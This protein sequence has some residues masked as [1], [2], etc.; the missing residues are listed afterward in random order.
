MRFSDD[1]TKKFN[2][3]PT[4]DLEAIFHQNKQDES[5]LRALSEVLSRRRKSKA[6]KRLRSDVNRQLSRFFNP[7]GKERTQRVS[8]NVGCAGYTE[9]GRKCKN[10]AMYFENDVGWC[11][12]HLPEQSAKPSR[13]HR[14]SGSRMTQTNNSHEAQSE[15]PSIPITIDPNV[16]IKA[17]DPKAITSVP[18][19]AALRKNLLESLNRGS[20]IN[21]RH[22]DRSR[23]HIRI[24]N[25]DFDNAFRVLAG[26]LSGSS[27]FAPLSEPPDEPSDERSE[28]FMLAYLA[29]RRDSQKIDHLESTLDPDDEKDQR[30]LAQAERKIK[31][32]VRISLG[33]GQRLQ[34]GVQTAAQIARS[35]KINPNHSLASETL[36]EPSGRITLQTLQYPREMSAKLNAIRTGA[37]RAM[38][39]SGS[40]ALHA[41]FGF[42]EWKPAGGR[43]RSIMSP[44]LLAPLEFSR[45]D[46][47]SRRQYVVY[48][49]GDDTTMNPALQVQLD[50]E[51]IM[52]PEWDGEE[53]PSHYLK[54][55]ESKISSKSGWKVHSFLTIGL[56]ESAVINV[57]QDLDP[58][59]WPEGTDPSLHNV[60]ADLMAGSGERSGDLV[61]EY[62]IDKPDIAN[63]L[64]EPVL[65]ADS[66]QLSAMIDVLDGKNLAIQG[67][68]GTGKSQTITNTIAAAMLRGK[69]VL[70]VAEKMAALD[71]VK[72]RLD[73][74]GLGDFVLELHSTK[75]SRASVYKSFAPRME[76]ARRLSKPFA[77]ERR[78]RELRSVK[79]TLNEYVDL[80]NKPLE[81]VGST[82]H[83]AMWRVMSLEKETFPDPLKAVEIKNASNIDQVEL[84][85]TRDALRAYQELHA[86]VSED[87]GSIELH[88]WNF[89]SKELTPIDQEFVRQQ[90]SEQLEAI[91]Q[92]KRELENLVWIGFSRDSSSTVSALK[93]ALADVF[94]LPNQL[95]ENVSDKL[96]KAIG[97]RIQRKSLADYCEAI[98][99]KNALSSDIGEF[100]TPE[101]AIPEPGE[102]ER[103][104]D[105]LEFSD[106]STVQDL[107]TRLDDLESLHR[108]LKKDYEAAVQLFRASDIEIALTGENLR[109]LEQALIALQCT[110]STALRLRSDAYVDDETLNEIAKAESISES[111]IKEIRRLSNANV[112]QRGESPEL[113]Q[114]HVNSL[115]RGGWFNRFK[116]STKD[117]IRHWQS[118]A[119]TSEKPSNE[120]IAEDL[121][122]L[123]AAILADQTINSNKLLV[124][125]TGRNLDGIESDFQSIRSVAEYQQS[126][127]SLRGYD[128]DAASKLRRFL[129]SASISQLVRLTDVAN[130][131][132]L[133]PIV[134]RDEL[135]DS[136]L[137]DSKIDEVA[138]LRDVAASAFNV[139]NMFGLDG[140]ADA[141]A[142]GQLRDLCAKWHSI[143]QRVRGMDNIKHLL[144][145][146]NID[147]DSIGIIES[148]VNFFDELRN[149]EKSTDSKIAT[150][151][152]DGDIGKNLDRL[153]SDATKLIDSLDKLERLRTKTIDATSNDQINDNV[154]PPDASLNSIYEQSRLADENPGA[155]ARWVQLIST[156]LQAL[157]DNTTEVV[158]VFDR[159]EEKFDMPSIWEQM[160]W[161]SR[162]N[163]EF[164]QNQTLRR[165]SGYTQRTARERLKELDGEIVK[166]SRQQ[167]KFLLSQKEGPWGNSV[168]R[169][170]DLTQ[171]S[172]IE[173]LSTQQRPRVS[174]RDFIHRAGDAAV[175]LKPCFMMSP[176]S[177]A[178]YLPRGQSMFDIVLM[179]EASQIKTE[180]A[181]GSL[182][183]G[184]QAVIVGDTKQLPPTRFFERLG[185]SEFDDDDYQD[186]DVESVLEQALSRFPSRTLRWHYRSEHQDLIKFSN[187]HFY[188]NK[189]IVF[190]SAIDA[191]SLEMGVYF[192]HMPE[193]YYQSSASGRRGGLNPEQAN[194]VAKAAIKSMETRPDWSIGVVA[195]NKAQAEMIDDQ[196]HSLLQNSPRARKFVNDRENTL[197]PFFVKNL[198]NVQGDERDH[199]I[200]STVYGPT[201]P[202]QPTRQAFGPIG[203]QHGGRRLN[204]L[205]S[206]AKKRIDVISSMASSDV[207][208]AETPREGVK[209][210]NAYLEFAATG[211][212]GGPNEEVR[213][214][215]DS[216]FEASVGGA[217]SQAG[218]K[219]HYQVGVAGYKI[220]LG[221]RHDD[222]PYGYIAGVECDGATYHSAKSARDRDLLR[223]QQLER[224]GWH[225][226]RVWSTDWFADPE[227][228]TKRLIQGLT[229]RVQAAKEEF[230]KRVESAAFLDQ[231]SNYKDTG[232]LMGFFDDEVEEITV[233]E[234]SLNVDNSTS[235]SESSAEYTKESSGVAVFSDSPSDEPRSSEPPTEVP[236]GSRND[237]QDYM[238]DKI[239]RAT[240]WSEVSPTLADYVDA[241][242]KIQFIP[243][244]HHPTEE[245]EFNLQMMIETVIDVEGP[246][247]SDVIVDRIRN[248]YG[249]GGLR[250]SPRRRIQSLI[251][252]SGRNGIANRGDFYDL[253]G[254]IP[255]GKDRLPRV[256][257]DREIE[258]I[259]RTELL[260]VCYLVAESQK[261]DDREQ[262]L[263]EAA[264]ALGYDRIGGTI[265]SRLGSVI[266][267][268]IKR[269]E[270]DSENTRLQ[271][272]SSPN[273]SEN[274]L[275]TRGY[276]P[277]LD[278]ASRWMFL[279]NYV[280][281]ELTKDGAI[282]SLNTLISDFKNRPDTSES[283][284]KAMQE[285]MDQL[286]RFRG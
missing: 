239:D 213:G 39:E 93:Q 32:E 131:V 167:A 206:R 82:I 240:D 163:E 69:S 174:V 68:P 248:A 145:S 227:G 76:L 154:S 265:R 159:S 270:S 283:I 40:V 54:K 177:V 196:I 243:D 42:L 124:E 168:G 250:G 142:L 56:F 211:R 262:L 139:A 140:G 101:R 127:Q 63:R 200:I 220:D 242:K 44:L 7:T 225:I 222:F 20:L 231:D 260:A 46:W 126:V 115:R 165:A 144:S 107:G 118:L 180:E 132:L 34:K 187:H 77:Y 150:A 61:D 35:Q 137:I 24:V 221:I 105:A 38:E 173:H 230:Q 33:M 278:P 30:T 212:L 255:W 218:Y 273:I 55:I 23:S 286:R 5:I 169:V 120:T 284:K 122:I 110:S 155:I 216:D 185:L 148:T 269:S 78:L 18:L 233:D 256:A 272:D 282:N 192:S 79:D 15:S 28:R 72:K 10:A 62:E 26:Q 276:D 21:L 184:K 191:D 258:Q 246:V 280:I 11:N 161:K 60:V 141:L 203:G 133:E 86:G 59:R 281:P 259:D 152:I 109:L 219:V 190:P 279:L 178:K 128:V 58:E 205:F 98:R 138:N 135:P 175:A 2:Q 114:E 66:S 263:K 199:I 237:D 75:V 22:S 179:D 134:T 31:D 52:L 112:W 149:I 182:A 198:E 247:H 193:A 123:G 244:K 130:D 226:L 186:V 88:P 234:R 17:D 164:K 83:Q 103:I 188:D 245:V 4:A 41:A 267:E 254:Q 238:F 153:R 64:P 49:Q 94:K 121:E 100:T 275:V 36:D 271:N 90:I 3:H 235:Q 51:N 277:Q 257:G 223:Q 194:H 160:F 264:N 43:D 117:A 37:S 57:W 47:Q 87:F 209:A 215:P 172:L 111:T 157:N 274:P 99:N 195:V 170:S 146:L 108:K 91:S 224:L 92:V 48:P 95:P 136:E 19:T 251:A 229:Q 13:S 204:V 156:R 202:G 106:A 241:A 113:L 71:V 29:E 116:Q 1:I 14:T 249:M 151:I 236:V 232:Y 125:F 73:D 104:I 85:S 252:S 97:E 189:L 84:S 197:E 261:I 253:Y 89:V 201:G 119:G 129:E 210:L 158:D 6:A 70:F 228:E 67:P 81:G 45:S 16:W 214:I 171:T 65:D 181:I 12:D 143:D 207:K 80:V 9:V 183:R 96:V 176:S 74:V 266:D 102:L 147:L 162:I 8:G 217:L 53:L 208:V 166:L 268:F 285:D 25:V 50:N 27:E